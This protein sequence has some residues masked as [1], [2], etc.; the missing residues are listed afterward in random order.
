MCTPVCERER[1]RINYVK[2]VIQNLHA[3]LSKD[4][5]KYIL[6]KTP[7]ETT[8]QNHKYAVSRVHS[9]LNVHGNH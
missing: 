8:F 1:Q 9:L 4:R 5:N 3:L 7:Q 6:L 2:F